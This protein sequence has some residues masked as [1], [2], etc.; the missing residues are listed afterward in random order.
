MAVLHQPVAYGAA[1]LLL[2]ENVQKRNVCGQRG[3]EAVHLQAETHV[4][5][6][7]GNSEQLLRS[8][9]QAEALADVGDRVGRVDLLHD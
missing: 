9:T 2:E 5:L 4:V 3:A 7:V 1:H 8:G 6:E